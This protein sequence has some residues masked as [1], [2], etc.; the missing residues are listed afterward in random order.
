MN[1]LLFVYGALRRGASNDWRMKDATW[2]GAA[3]VPGTLIKV[4]WYPGL[5]LEGEGSVVGEVYQLGEELLAELDHF[6][7]IGKETTTGEYQR[8][9]ATVCLDSEEQEVWLYQWRK[10]IAHYEIVASGDWLA[11]SK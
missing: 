11:A 5:V 9:R 7:G 4:D 8:V 1:D 6:E 3:T 10:G 2:I